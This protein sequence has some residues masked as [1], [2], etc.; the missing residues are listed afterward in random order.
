[1]IR[2]ADE[3][4]VHDLYVMER[5]ASSTA[6][7]HV[8]GDTAFPAADV[9]ARWQLVID[10]PTAAVLLD[11]LDGVPVGYAAFGDG[12]LR[13]FGVVPRLWGTGRAHALYAAV[14]EASTA[15]GAPATYLWVLVDNRRAR[16]FYRQLGWHDTDAREPETFAPYP[17]K[18]RMHRVA[19]ETS[20]RNATYG[21]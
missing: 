9:L 19:D 10:D 4:D 8:F 2:R 1:M 16:A 18:M 11:E 21:S 3:S 14:L 13:H 17:L 5:A 15:A 20:A 7:A 6:L 12:W